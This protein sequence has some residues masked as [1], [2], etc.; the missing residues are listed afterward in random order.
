[1]LR[2]RRAGNIGGSSGL[3]WSYDLFEN[4]VSNNYYDWHAQLETALPLQLVVSSV[5]STILE[6]SNV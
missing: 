6:K 1:M 4:G 3:A 5:D 2:L